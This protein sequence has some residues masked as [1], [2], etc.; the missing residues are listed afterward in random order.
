MRAGFGHA[1]VAEADNL[2]HHVFQLY[3]G[4][5]PPLPPEN[6]ALLLYKNVIRSVYHD[7]R[8]LRIFDQFLQNIEP[9]HGMEQFLL[10]PEFFFQKKIA[11]PAAGHDSSSISA[12]TSSSVSSLDRSSLS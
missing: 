3:S 6:S 12:C 4:G 2:L 9:P 10:H 7:L 8:H 1:P 5:K 11:A